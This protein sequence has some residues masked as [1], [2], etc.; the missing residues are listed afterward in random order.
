MKFS[1]VKTKCCHPFKSGPFDKRKPDAGSSLSRII[2]F[3]W[4]LLLNFGGT[5][6]TSRLITKKGIFESMIFRLSEKVVHER[7][8]KKDDEV[9]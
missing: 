6:V 7:I 8:G 9:V 2:I 5:T 1:T 4:F 3:Q